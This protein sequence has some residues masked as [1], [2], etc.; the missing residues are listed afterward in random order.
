MQS[1]GQPNRQSPHGSCFWHAADTPP[2]E[3]LLFL[4][5]GWSAVFDMLHMLASAQQ[6]GMGGLITFLTTVRQGP[7]N[8]FA[9][10]HFGVDAS[11]GEKKGM[12]EPVTDCTWNMKIMNLFLPL[13][14][15]NWLTAQ[16]KHN[17]LI[18]SHT[19]ANWNG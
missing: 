14:D 19:P 1:C 2:L 16:A 9:E 3:G 10:K 15:Q 11:R 18:L 6:G 8:L 12:D 17:S 13:E 4:A 5:C 7:R